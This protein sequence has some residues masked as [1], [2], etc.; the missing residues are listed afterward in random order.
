M[1][2]LITT[3]MPGSAVAWP[4][5]VLSRDVSAAQVS[6]NHISANKQVLNLSSHVIIISH[7]IAQHMSK[8]TEP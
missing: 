2:G 1:S 7:A 8:I 3:I 4:G 5:S 6:D